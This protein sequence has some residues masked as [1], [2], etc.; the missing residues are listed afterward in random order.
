MP[1]TATFALSGD[2]YIDGVLGGPKWAVNDLTFS[3]PSSASFY[4]AGYGDGEPTDNFG[5][6]NAAQ[7]FAARATFNMISSVANLAFTEVA[8]TSTAHADLR[9]AMSDAPSTAWAY[10]P[11]TAA[12]GGDAWFNRSNGYYDSPA[13]GNYAYTTFLH[14]IGHA[15]GLEHA[16]EGNVMPTDRD[17]MEY[18]VMSYRS[19]VGGSTSGGYTNETWGYAQSLMMYD[20]AGL[21]H[22]YGADY[23]TNSANT[24]YSWSPTTGEMFVNGIGQGAPGA[25]RIFLTVWDGGGTDTYDFSSYTTNLKIDLRPGEWTITSSAQLAKL[26]YD[27]SKVAVGNIANALLYNND[28]RSLIENARGGSGNDVITGNA[29]SNGLWGGA[30]NDTFYGREGND[31]LRGG[32]GAD[33]LD[34]GSGADMANYW[35]AAAT[36]AA[37][38]TG[39]IADLAWQGLNT[40][41]AAGDRYVSIE[42]LYGSTFNDDLRGDG[43]S[44]LICGGPGG[45]VIYGRGSN[46]QIQ[47]GDGHDVLIGGYGGD[48]LHGGKGPDIFLFQG[49]GDSLPTQRDTIADFSSGLDKIDLRRLDANRN[50][51]GDQAFSFIGDSEFTGSAGELQFR[52]GMLSGDVDADRMVDFQVQLTNVSVLIESDFWL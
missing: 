21:Q 14:E 50:E 1:A 10:L 38:G 16:H 15:V 20:I 18:T 48:W 42:Q 33:W 11:S 36:S 31:C 2:P 17:S 32:P 44:N 37:K 6:L 43:S 13:K 35:G 26:H 28:A 46:D 7:Q 41:E 27:G 49:I 5:S 45:D 8:E 19:Y 52:D 30:G 40:G 25:N 3:F 39:I 29:T 22:M 9:L 23:T 24:T 12:E 34:G 51:A 4:G 47:G